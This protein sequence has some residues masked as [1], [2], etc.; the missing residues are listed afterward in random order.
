M[1]KK[2]V[3]IVIG[4]SK[5]IGK[6]IYLNFKKQN[7]NAI[8]ISR[9]LKKNKNHIYLDLSDKN[10]IKDQIKSKV[11]PKFKVKSLIGR[12]G[13]SFHEYMGLKIYQAF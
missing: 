7:K 5:G 8:V 13:C 12:N 1:K 3:N 6:A 4:G 11:L 10:A 9:S 2:E